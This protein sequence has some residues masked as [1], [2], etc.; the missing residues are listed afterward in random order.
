[1]SPEGQ[2]CSA[3]E[4]FV[5][6]K[7]FTILGYRVEGSFKFRVKHSYFSAHAEQALEES[8]PLEKF[9]WYEIG[10]VD[11]KCLQKPPTP[12]PTNSI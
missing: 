12:M 11:P 10:L 1:M 4:V 8:V 7:H 9:R 3:A 5:G 2:E 6:L